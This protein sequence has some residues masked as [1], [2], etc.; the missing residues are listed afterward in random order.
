[1][2]GHAATVDNY[3]FFRMFMDD[4]RPDSLGADNKQLCDTVMIKKM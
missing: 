3:T 2:R 4:Q 1:M